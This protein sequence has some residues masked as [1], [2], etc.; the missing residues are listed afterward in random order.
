MIH[1]LV[2]DDEAQ[3]ANGIA[4]LL[5]CEALGIGAV[6]VAYSAEEALRKLADAP[7]GIVLT[8]IRMPDRDGISLL[9]AIKERWK[10]TKVIMLTGYADFDYAKE[11]LQGQAT[12]YLLKPVR[13]ETLEAAVAK[14]M[15]QLRREWEEIASAQRAMR[16]L[17]AYEPEL[18][19]K[20]LTDLIAGF[21]MAE[22][23]LA[24]KLAWFGLPYRK[25]DSCVLLL[26]RTEQNAVPAD[27]SDAALLAYGL[28][29]IAE[30]T[31]SDD[32]HFWRCR[33]AHGHLVFLVKPLERAEAASA[34]LAIRDAE[35]CAVLF[36]KHSE[37]FLKAN[38]TVYRSAIG[39]FPSRVA[40]MYERTLA[41][42]RDGGSPQGQFLVKADEARTAAPGYL[43]CLHEPPLLRHL[44]E[45]GDWDAIG[46]KLSLALEHAEASDGSRTEQLTEVYLTFAAA[47]CTH[48]HKRGR[49]LAEF[50]DAGAGQN[51]DTALLW[52]ST[53][54]KGW[55]AE[56]LE[57]LRKEGD[58]RAGGRS[59]AIVR[60]QQFIAERL[61]E[62]LSLQRM[63]DYVYMHPTHL[64]KIYKKETGEGISEYLTRLRMERAAQLL[65][66]SDVKIYEI[67]CMTGYMNANYFIK[68]F[69][70]QFGVTPQE[71]RERLRRD[72]REE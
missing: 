45:I 13:K 29:N 20:L 16:T 60:L 72:L 28:E 59:E 53:R 8:D 55:I 67:G 71:Y 14:A 43:S 11:A 42:I 1:V 70:R 51:A 26:A 33:D 31:F 22:S 5:P 69:R 56:T 21:R 47:L 52:T 62:D 12:D 18:K 57:R 63:A 64:S 23:E 9:R 34:E 35:R 50:L 24:E 68:V 46:S 48:L 39:E 32:F 19:A 6:H 38:V 30:E 37:Q 65:G 36:H 2:V 54:L 17:R 27:R 15:E 3:I 58:E 10:R 40:D 49:R 61:S 7:I 66:S 44:F 25:G 41:A 4:A